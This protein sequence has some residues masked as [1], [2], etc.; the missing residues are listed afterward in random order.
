GVGRFEQARPTAR[1]DSQTN[2]TVAYGYQAQAHKA[3]GSRQQFVAGTE[4][5]DESIAGERYLTEPTGVVTPSRP[6]IPAGTTYSSFGAFAQHSADVVPNRLTL[7]GGLRASSF[8]FAT[9]ANQ[10]LGVIDERVSTNAVTFQGSAVV[11]I[12]DGLNA[13]ANVSRGFRAAN[14]ADLGNIG[15]TGGGGFEITPSQ[16]VEMGAIVGSTGGVDAR[17]TGRDLE[18]LRPEVVYQYDF[19][20]K[21]QSG[22]VSAAVNVFDLE[23]HDFIQRRSLVFDTN[24]VG[25]SIAGF[26]IVR[27]D[28][29]GLAYIAQ[30]IRPIA[31]RVNV[32]RGR[33]NGFD[34]VGDVR[35]S[36]AWTASAFFSMANG[37]VIPTGAYVRRMPPP[38]GQ[39]KVR[40]QGQR[41]WAEGVVN[42]AMEQTRL[43]SG[44]LA[45]ARI[46]ATRTRASIATFFNGTATD[47]GLVQNGV[48]V[49]TGETLAAVQTRVLGTANS[50]PMFT[51]QPGFA[52]LSLR[53]GINL[54]AGVELSV[55]GENL[56]DANYRLYG[57]GVDAPGRSFHARVGYRF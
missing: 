13:T 42:V 57:S 35:L 23:L 21:G 38:M 44:D 32:D 8:R 41:V 54:G 5:Y 33:I 45:D 9:K 39:A 53:G 48:L 34:A 50:A 47:M 18:A 20:M 24:V 52:A 49:Q 1:L 26:E 36:R 43:D 27:Q 10:A 3:L 25:T 31:S 55:I 14:A 30:D 19:G 17:S 11:R 51:S 22:R 4:F 46:G 6:D 16:G 28:A 37:H 56:S 7:R 29:F 12:T 2:S 40:W 15:L